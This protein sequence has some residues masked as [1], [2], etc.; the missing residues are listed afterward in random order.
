[1]CCLLRK[2]AEQSVDFPLLLPCPSALSSSGCFRSR[3]KAGR[4]NSAIYAVLRAGV[5]LPL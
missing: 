2:E 4:M 1:M 5:D 3:L